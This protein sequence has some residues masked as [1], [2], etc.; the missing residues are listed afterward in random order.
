MT[1][2]KIERTDAN[3]PFLRFADV[4][5][6]YA[7]AA[8]EAN[9]APTDEALAALNRVRT[10]SNATPK[11]LTGNGNIGNLVDFRS[12][13][14]EERAMELALEGDRR[15]DLI[16]WGIYL[17][18]MNAI[19]GVD[20]VNVMKSRQSKHLLFPLPKSEMDANSAITENNP[21]W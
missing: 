21:G 18:V 10:R 13:V 8:N 4:L 5:L 19:G 16:R 15:W 6:I 12:A 17:P 11:T 2:N 20:E 3:W 9:N 7:E 1:D 14:I